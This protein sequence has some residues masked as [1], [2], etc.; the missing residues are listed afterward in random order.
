M[1]F[2]VKEGEI[3]WMLLIVIVI[4]LLI[5]LWIFNSMGLTLFRRAIHFLD[6][7]YGRSSF[8]LCVAPRNFERDGYW[9]SRDCGCIFPVLLPMYDLDRSHF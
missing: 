1:S 3:G 7:I 9:V 4:R 5:H 6:F 8:D 2:E